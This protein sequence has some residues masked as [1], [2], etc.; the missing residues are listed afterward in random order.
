VCL[1]ILEKFS[2]LKLNIDF[3]L[4]YSPERINPG[5]KKHR[6]PNINKVVSGSSAFIT[7]KIFFLYKK[8]IRAKVI[9]ASSIKIAEAAKVIENTQRDVN[10]ALINEFQ[11]IFDNMNIRS[12]DVFDIARTKWNFLDFR[13]GLVGGHCIGVDPYYLSYKSKKMGYNPMLITAGR[14]IND[15]MHKH[16]NK[17]I[18]NILKIEKELNL[19]KVNILFLGLT[20]KE[21]CPDIRNSRIFHMIED[22]TKRG[23]SVEAFDPIAAIDFA[24][25]EKIEKKYN[26]KIIAKPKKNLYT[27]IILMV[28]HN[29]FKS[30]GRKQILSYLKKEKL[31]LDYKNLFAF[32]NENYFI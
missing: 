28:P 23:I 12:K 5:D 19:R 11:M 6:L 31:F 3:G 1:P 25:Q 21:N 26:F 13:P 17:K 20:F 8:I 10:I 9:R 4:G 7:E 24:T 32:K 29:E 16:L 15:Q 2:K 30:I 27:M 18:I 22:L 14:K